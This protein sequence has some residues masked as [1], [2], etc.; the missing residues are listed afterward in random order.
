[1]KGLWR[2][3]IH[4]IIL[5]TL[6]LFSSS[7]AFPQEK[8]RKES[9]RTVAEEYWKLRFEDKYED[10]YTMED[11]EG[12]PPLEDYR[13]KAALLKRLTITSHSIKDVRLDG[14]KGMADVVLLIQFPNVP[15]PLPDVMRDEW[16]YRDGKW[17]HMFT[18]KSNEAALKSFNSGLLQMPRK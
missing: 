4:V 2:Q 17:R 18:T 10:T 13:K 16:V 15:K 12:L 6:L 1:M 7:I 5:M 8:D 9:L 3:V 14:D 11:K